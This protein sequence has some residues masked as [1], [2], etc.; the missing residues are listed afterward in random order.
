MSSDF[1]LTIPLAPNV[2][3]YW[4]VMAINDAQSSAWS[5]VRTFRT[6]LS[7]PV[8]IAPVGSITV[9]SL[10]P[11]FSWNKVIGATGYTLQVSTSTSF[12]TL[13]FPAATLTNVASYI[14]VANLPKSTTLY[15]RLCANGTNGPSDWMPYATFKTP[16]K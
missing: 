6:K 9:S 10:K 8:P 7:A 5:A 16:I 4:R 12:K 1:T 15:W 11:T 2:T 14:P 13:V 3:W